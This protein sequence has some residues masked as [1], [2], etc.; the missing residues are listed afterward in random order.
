M[1]KDKK[2]IVMYLLLTV[3]FSAVCQFFAIRAY[4]AEEISILTI[5]VS[6]LMWCPAIAALII[7]KIYYPKENILGF[8]LSKKKYI[9]VGI[10][11]PVVEAIAC[12][13]IYIIIYGSGI[14]ISDTMIS[15]LQSPL[16]L[17]FELVLCLITALGEEIG[18]R[19]FLTPKV[20]NIFGLKK[21]TLLIGIIWSLWHYPM[22]ISGYMRPGGQAPLWLEIILYTIWVIIVTFIYTYL[23]LC[24]K[25]IWPAVFLHAVCNYLGSF[26]ISALVNSEIMS[27]YLTIDATGFVDITVTFILAYMLTRI[28]DHKYL[29]ASWV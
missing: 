21:G 27:P 26:I 24:S 15:L 10:F 17:L 28:V 19:G 12:V 23:R 20:T 4:Y 11:L 18:W 22:M 3:I 16:T 9:L 8:R 25:S 2:S 6:I 14:L 7:C 5:A 1:K 29:P 13:A